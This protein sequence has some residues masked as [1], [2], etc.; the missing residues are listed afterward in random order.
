VDW[1]TTFPFGHIFRDELGGTEVTGHPGTNGDVTI[2]DDVWIGHGV[3]IMSG[4]TVG[5]G[6]V[7]AANTHVVKDVPPH[8]I[9][10]GNPGRLLKRRFD[11]E[12]IGLL[13]QLKWWDLPLETIRDIIPKLSAAP[14]AATLRE[15]I[16]VYRP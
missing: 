13:L 8:G 4:I 12:T 9:D 16:A 10:G 11:E 15:M 1:I 6:A 3:T 2:G 5:T 7:I 14:D